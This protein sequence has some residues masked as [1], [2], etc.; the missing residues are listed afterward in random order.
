MRKKKCHCLKKF[1]PTAI[2]KNLDPNPRGTVYSF[3]PVRR[4][5]SSN[6]FEVIYWNQETPVQNFPVSTRWPFS[7]LQILIAF[8][9]DLRLWVRLWK[10]LPIRSSA[11]NPFLLSSHWIRS[12]FRM[13][14]KKKKAEIS[15]QHFTFGKIHGHP[16]KHRPLSIGPESHF[17]YSALIMRCTY[18]YILSI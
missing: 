8:P 3:E 11:N 4:S 9:F 16:L 13:S 12:Q 18:S 14:A 7:P 5:T 15:L 6:L 10:K 17:W 1:L 2:I